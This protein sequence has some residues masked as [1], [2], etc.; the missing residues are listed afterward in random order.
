M[1]NAT[2]A[3]RRNRADLLGTIT[4]LEAEGAVIQ[5][6]VSRLESRYEA[7]LKAIAAMRQLVRNYDEEIAKG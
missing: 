3:Y 1:S 5:S 6:E 7:N 4:Q 2:D